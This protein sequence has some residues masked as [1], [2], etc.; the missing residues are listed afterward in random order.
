MTHYTLQ[1]NIHA[2][3]EG[4]LIVDYPRCE[5]LSCANGACFNASQRCDG[6]VDCRDSSDEANCSKYH[7]QSDPKQICILDLLLK[8]K[9]V[10][11]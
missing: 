6:K 10:V 11:F 8:L 2:N 7:M 9:T 4:F 1:S 3:T 5:Q